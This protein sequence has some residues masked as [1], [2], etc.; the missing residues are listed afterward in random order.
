MPAKILYIEDDNKLARLV[1]NFLQSHGFEV[2]HLPSAEG[3][4]DLLYYDSFDLLLLDIGLPTDDGISLCRQI[5]DRFSG[6]ILFMTARRSAVDEV[7][8]LMAGAD[9]Y[10]TKPVAP[11]ILLA[12]IQT[13]LKRREPPETAPAEASK[14]STEM[15]FGRLCIRMAA[16]QAFLDEESLR[17]TTAEFDI[18]AQLAKHAGQIVSREDLFKYTTGAPYDGLNR[19]MDNRISRLRRK[20]GDNMDDPFKIKTIW[21][22]GYLFVPDI[23]G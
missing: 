23:W 12:R 20:L 7:E 18:L 4:L 16:Q 15:Q 6:Q 11:E 10:L 3:A 9:D 22:K 8:G 14:S 21:G 5:R 17:L 19:T 1:T 13:R 2:T